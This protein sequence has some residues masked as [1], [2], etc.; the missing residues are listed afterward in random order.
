METIEG[1]F[2]ILKSFQD[3]IFVYGSKNLIWGV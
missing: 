2:N 1:K 3:K